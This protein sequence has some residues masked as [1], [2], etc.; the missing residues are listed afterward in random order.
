MLDFEISQTC[1]FTGHRIL[2][3]EK[4]DAIKARL[5]ETVEG[6]IE[7]GYTCF[8]SG[9]ALGFDLLAAEIVLEK[10]RNHPHIK[11][12]MALPCHDQHK[13]W[14]LRDR[15]RYEN[16]LALADEVTYVCQ[17]YCTGCM[18]LRNKFMVNHSSFCIAYF[19][20]G[21]GTEYTVN[22]AREKDI[23]VINLAYIL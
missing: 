23:N 22:Y 21:G 18:H 20:G 15:K 2:P 11:L 14:G 1:C 10:K 9:G 5:S 7:N 8:V 4:L 13:K 17:E 19:T 16:I 6:L 12:G 3:A